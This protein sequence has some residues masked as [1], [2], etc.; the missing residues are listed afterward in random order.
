MEKQLRVNKAI[1]TTQARG[2]STIPESGEWGRGGGAAASLTP[3]LGPG[4]SLVS[5]GAVRGDGAG[6]EPLQ[7]FGSLSWRRV[8]N[9][10]AP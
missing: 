4:R 6:I 1:F 5:T 9:A 2:P 8:V 10:K 7:V 3:A